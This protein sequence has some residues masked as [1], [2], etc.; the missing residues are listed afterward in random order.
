MS[1]LS[2]REGLGLLVFL[3]NGWR[4]SIRSSPAVELVG[5]GERLLLGFEFVRLV[6][7]DDEDE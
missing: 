7:L 5:G 1:T 6:V 4:E 3:G 2:A